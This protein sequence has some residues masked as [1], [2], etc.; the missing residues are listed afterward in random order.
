MYGARCTLNYTSWRN[1]LQLVGRE[2]LERGFPIKCLITSLGGTAVAWGPRVPVS[3]P[4]SSEYPLYMWAPC[5][6][7]LTSWVSVLSMVWC[8]TL[9]TRCQL[10]CRSR[11]LSTAQNYEVRPKIERALV[12]LRNG[13]LI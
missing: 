2:S 6:L 10:R 7:N 12:L 1:V 11:H 9:D 3:K 4:D 13:T 5:T 8:G